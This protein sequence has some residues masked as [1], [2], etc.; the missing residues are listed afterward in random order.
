MKAT[1]REISDK[2]KSLSSQK[3]RWHFHLL[4]KGCAFNKGKDKYS[5]VLE[6]ESSGKHLVFTAARKPLAQS[7]ALAS[8]MYGKGFLK[9]PG[10]GVFGGQFGKILRRA[11]E[12]DF[13]GIDWHHHHLHPACMFN[14]WK[15]RHC[16]VLEDKQKHRVL[17]AKYSREPKR[18]IAEIERLFYKNIR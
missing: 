7:K 9:K 12:L 2:A 15:G 6:D 11:K 3:K 4:G 10:K 13:K 14:E 1:I 8:L 17:V 18:E 16:L 5:I